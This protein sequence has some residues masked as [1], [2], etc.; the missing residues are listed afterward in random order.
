MVYYGVIVSCV[1]TSEML[2]DGYNTY[3]LWI[4]RELAEIVKYWTGSARGSVL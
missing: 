4:L 2:I 1:M 3:T